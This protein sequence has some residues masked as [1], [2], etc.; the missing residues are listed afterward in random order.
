MW[1]CVAY[2]MNVDGS[3]LNQKPT[4]WVTNSK[5]IALQLQRRCSRDHTHVNLMGGKAVKAAE[6]PKELCKANRSGIKAAPERKAKTAKARG[7]FR[8]HHREE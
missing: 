6:Y 5:K 1:I 2:G 3:G 8:D 4:C 7:S